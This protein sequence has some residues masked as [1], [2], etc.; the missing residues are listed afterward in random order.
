M[1]EKKKSEDLDPSLY[2]SYRGPALQ[3]DGERS[4]PYEPL[5]NEGVHSEL[6]GGVIGWV[7]VLL[8]IC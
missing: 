5:A 7:G 4:R 6:S 8:I 2:L 1:E 3:K